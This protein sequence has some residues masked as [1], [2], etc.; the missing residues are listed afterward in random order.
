[1]NQQRV[2]IFGLTALMLIRSQ[3]LDKAEVTRA[4]WDEMYVWATNNGYSFD[5]EGGGKA[6]A[7]PVQYVNWYDC[8]KWCNARSEQEGLTPVY[9]TTAGQTVLYKTGQLAIS[10]ACVK[11]S[12]N[13]YRL[14]TEAEWE[15]AA[16]GGITGH[17]FPWSDTDAIIHGFANYYSYWTNGAPTDPYDISN[18]LSTN[19]PRWGFAVSGG[20]RN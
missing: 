1:M 3:G 8:I 6:G 15:K 14:P 2:G 13:G 5:N 12:A 7:H 11:W 18:I 10:N 19:A 17:R 9:Y 20:I 16:R 4:K